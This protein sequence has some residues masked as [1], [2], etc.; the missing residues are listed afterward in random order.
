M[1]LLISGV[2]SMDLQDK[3]KQLSERL[4]ADKPKP[5]I[6]TKENN[7]PP[8]RDYFV[9]LS[10][11]KRNEFIQNI[12][13][14]LKELSFNLVSETTN[15]LRYHTPVMNEVDADSLV[16]FMEKI[17]SDSRNS[18]YNLAFDRTPESTITYSD[19]I[20]AGFA[21]VYASKYLD[22]EQEKE[23]AQHLKT[24]HYL[25]SLFAFESQLISPLFKS[26]FCDALI[27]TIKDAVDVS[28]V[29]SIIPTED[30]VKSMVYEAFDFTLKIGKDAMLESHSQHYPH[31]YQIETAVGYSYPEFTAVRDSL[32]DVRVN[33]YYEAVKSIISNRY[34]SNDTMKALKSFKDMKPFP[35]QLDTEQTSDDGF[36]IHY[37]LSKDHI[38]RGYASVKEEICRIVVKTA[39]EYIQMNKAHELHVKMTANNANRN[40]MAAIFVDSFKNKVNIQDWKTVVGDPIIAPCEPHVYVA[41]KVKKMKPL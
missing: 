25:Q 7:K 39:I 17:K 20:K 12:L 9:K 15:T 32:Q 2:L 10:F 24:E 18:F 40:E 38:E 41:N 8:K 1:L 4:D 35:K 19:L 37:F 34:D 30:P 6:S 22:G 21:Q 23:I 26:K 36:S 29:D 27:D 28:G 11:D 33:N 14:D 16:K 3:I 31:L 13:P 5:I